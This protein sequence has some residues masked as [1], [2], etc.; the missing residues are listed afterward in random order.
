MNLGELEGAL[1]LIVQE[2]SLEPYY[3]GWINNAILELATDY[4]LP[5]LKLLT[6]FPL[7]VNT[8][9][10]LWLLP[11]NF[12]KKLFRCANGEWGR[13]QVEFQGKPFDISYLDALDIDHDRTADHVTHA[14]VAEVG[15]DHYLGLFPK[16]NE[17]L[18]LWF[19]QKPAVL[20]KPDDTPSCIPSGFHE[21][22][23]IPRVIIKNFQLLQDQ[24]ENFDLKPLQYWEGKQKEGL[25]GSPMGPIGLINYLIKSQ[26]GPR[27]HGGRDPIWT[28]WG[29]GWGR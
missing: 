14:A 27:R 13:V 6:P 3:K 1:S 5:A 11:D 10:W 25:Y 23:I 7:E 19:Y 8:S 29:S 2:K 26:G 20:D 9:N 15:D 18:K 24:V 4:E 21:R 17:I 28:G 22:V 16:A 12:Q